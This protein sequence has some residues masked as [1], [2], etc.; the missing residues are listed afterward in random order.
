MEI[1]R[2]ISTLNAINLLNIQ[3]EVIDSDALASMK[4]Q[5]KDNCEW[6]II[7]ISYVYN[8]ESRPFVFQLSLSKENA[9]MVSRGI[10]AVSYDDVVVRKYLHVDITCPVQLDLLRDL[11][12]RLQQLGESRGTLHSTRRHPLVKSNP[13]GSPTLRLRVTNSTR[14]YKTSHISNDVVYYTSACEQDVVPGCKLI[15][16]VHTSCVWAK[17]S[18]TESALVSTGVC[19][20]AKDVVIVTDDVCTTRLS[21]NNP[22]CLCNDRMLPV[23]ISNVEAVHNALTNE[24]D[25]G[26]ESS[27]FEFEDIGFD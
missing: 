8:G 25:W 21:K 26:E 24:D 10:T 12:A 16:Q 23:V 22:F 19:S 9:N 5:Q 13:C 4:E 17:T 3:E 1:G 15:S 14:Y 11:D 18:T 20:I 6:S 2:C 27:D 7:P